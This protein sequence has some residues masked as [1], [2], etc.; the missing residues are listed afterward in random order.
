MAGRAYASIPQRLCSPLS[1]RVIEHEAEAGQ[2][3]DKPEVAQEKS[4]VLSRFGR[5]GCITIK[6]SVTGQKQ[7]M[8]NSRIHI[9][10][11]VDAATVGKGVG[12]RKVARCREGRPS[13]RVLLS[14]QLFGACICIYC[15][16]VK[17]RK[18]YDLL[19]PVCE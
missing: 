19:P 15:L 1:T 7:A 4:M 14:F 12:H 16:I 3:H 6:G 8:P 13:K 2:R 17:D 11:S 5:W 9:R 18:K 10:H